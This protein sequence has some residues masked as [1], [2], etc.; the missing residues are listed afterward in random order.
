MRYLPIVLNLAISLFVAPT[1]G[2]L[3][4]LY[5]NGGEQ[6]PVVPGLTVMLLSSAAYWIWLIGR[7]A[8]RNFDA[9]MSEARMHTPAPADGLEPLVLDD[10]ESAMAQTPRR[11]RADETLRSHA[12]IPDPLGNALGLSAGEMLVERV[13]ELRDLKLLIADNRVTLLNQWYR[14]DRRNVFGERDYGDWAFEADRFLMSSAFKAKTL[15]RHE[16]IAAI[17]AEIEW[18]GDVSNGTAPAA[19]AAAGSKEFLE[20]CTSALVDN[21]W[22]THLAE[23]A[24]L[25]GVD[26]FAEQRD[27]II[28]LR[29]NAANTPVSEATVLDV[30]TARDVYSLDGVGVVS[31]TGFTASARSVGTANGVYLLEQSDLSDLH[32][33]LNE[34]SKVVPLFRSAG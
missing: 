34:P 32:Y 21:G 15:N 8:N 12:A 14:T 26:L 7:R 23:A 19:A 27:M 20:R 33:V 22:L 13:K 4:L 11:P 6:I 25:D 17:T 24:G 3:V 1:P 31:A 10:A 30:L 9:V 5:A 28:G 16:A 29:C 18:M 2:L